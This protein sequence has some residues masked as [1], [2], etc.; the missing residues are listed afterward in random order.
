MCVSRKFYYISM[1]PHIQ[2]AITEKVYLSVV[3][4][5]TVRF[6]TAVGVM[7]EEYNSCLPN[8]K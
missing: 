3:P 4:G 8:N 1:S 5:R 6:L 2:K 7:L